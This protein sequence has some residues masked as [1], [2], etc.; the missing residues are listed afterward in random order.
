MSER[1]QNGPVRKKKKKKRKKE[2][3][4]KWRVGKQTEGWTYAG[5]SLFVEHLL[6]TF[7][8]LFPQKLPTRTL[9]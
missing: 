3:R 6:Q 1:S 5:S 7:C 9:K 2:E 4:K 8:F